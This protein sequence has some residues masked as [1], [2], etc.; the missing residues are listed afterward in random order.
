VAAAIAVAGLLVRTPLAFWLATRHGPVKQSDLYTAVAPAAIAA[1][2]CAAAVWTLRQLPLVEAAAPIEG[3]AMT[4]VAGLCA[5]AL[6]F[7]A[8]P[9][10]RRALLA[11]R[12]LHLPQHPG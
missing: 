9:E 6:T 5:I 3:L 7:L 1:V 10:S 11:L 2:L 8:L 12:R 4:G